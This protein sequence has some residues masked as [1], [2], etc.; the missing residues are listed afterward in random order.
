MSLSINNI[1]KNYGKKQVLK[2]I[3]VNVEKGKCVGIL[4]LNG[5]GKSTFFNVL[6]GIC[7]C[8]SGTFLFDGVDMFSDKK[9]RSKLL[10]YITQNPPLIDE[11]SGL[12]NLKLWYNKKSLQAELE[13][14]VLKLLGVDEFLKVKVSKMSGG[15]KKRLAIG[16]AVAHRPSLLL[17]DEPSAALDLQCKER[18][19]AYLTQFKA[20]GGTV[21]IATHDIQDLEFCDK[22]VIFKDGIS[23]QYSYDGDASKL[24]AAL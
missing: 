19:A 23:Q 24:I 11:L 4:G 18:I 6:S 13:N 12:D 22:I 7:K 21:L 8:D 15:M 16:C 1:K 9:S 2:S 10:G 3:S 20:N 14:G 17:L 5:S